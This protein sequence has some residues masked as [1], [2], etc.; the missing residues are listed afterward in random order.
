MQTV[1]QT[2]CSDAV[3][4][5]W[6]WLYRCQEL[7]QRQGTSVWDHVE[8]TTTIVISDVI[9]DVGDWTEWRLGCQRHHVSYII[10]TFS[11]HRHPLDISCWRHSSHLIWPHIMCA[12]CV[13]R[14]WSYWLASQ[15]VTE[16][17][18]AAAN[19]RALSRD[20]MSDVG[21]MLVGHLVRTSGFL[22]PLVV[23]MEANFWQEAFEK[24]WVHSPL[25]AVL[26]CHS[27]GVT[28]V[29]RRLR[30]EVHDN[31]DNNN[32]SAWQ[33]GPLWPHR[34]GPITGRCWYSLN[35]VCYCRLTDSISKHWR[36]ARNTDTDH[37]QQDHTYRLVLA[38][39]TARLQRKDRPPVTPHLHSANWCCSLS[40]SLHS[41]HKSS[42]HDLFSGSV[43]FTLNLSSVPTVH[44]FLI[45]L[46]LSLQTHSS[47]TN[48][49]HLSL[50]VS[51]HRLQL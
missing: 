27:P 26:H 18:V 33:R 34:M 40:S 21:W 29:A 30:I 23:Q 6:N 11:A 7:E 43:F 45:F 46:T 25:R 44:H 31:D 38:W 42:F 47:S 49:D 13:R 36:N 12:L 32:D 14:D 48:S 51:T 10:I 22:Q 8:T 41:T 19:R 20:E 4:T 35:T 2:A 16:F 3:R 24:C 1:W 17:A 15:L 37:M 28:T 39:S 5:G 9:G 50:L